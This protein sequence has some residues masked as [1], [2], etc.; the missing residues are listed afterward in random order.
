MAGIDCD[1]FVS[2]SIS[3]SS[4]ERRLRPARD[5]RGPMPGARLLPAYGLSGGEDGERRCA[6]GRGGADGDQFCRRMGGWDP[7]NRTNTNSTANSMHCQSSCGGAPRSRAAGYSLKLMLKNWS[8]M[9]SAKRRR[10][11][12]GSSITLMTSQRVI[13]HLSHSSSAESDSLSVSH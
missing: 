13:F 10:F 2:V 4:H 7:S 9:V 12:I 3:S 1:G 5:H 6:E 11:E 8:Y